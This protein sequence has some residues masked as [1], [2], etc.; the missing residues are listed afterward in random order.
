MTYDLG[1]IQGEYVEPETKARKRTTATR[2]KVNTSLSGIKMK[3]IDLCDN[4]EFFFTW[5]ISCQLL[6]LAS[7]TE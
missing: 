2:D 7:E 3:V 5:Y 1:L 4:G 6:N